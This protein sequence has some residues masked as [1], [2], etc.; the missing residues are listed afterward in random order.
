MLLLTAFAVSLLSGLVPFVSIEVYLGGVAAATDAAGSPALRAALALVAGVG[1]TL[2]KVVWYLVAARSMETPWLRRKLAQERWRRGFERWRDRVSG[3]P[4]V[5]AA[6]L[7]A[8]AFAGFPP[9]MIIAVVAG[10]LRVPLS[11]YVPTVLVG[12]AA[13]FWLLLAGVDWFA[14]TL[15]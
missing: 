6:V 1:Q 2:A 7:L 13:R 9:L 15:F 10:S 3:R 4:V 5:S 14:E 11:L 12:R 8:S